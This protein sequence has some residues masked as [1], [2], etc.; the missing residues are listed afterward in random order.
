MRLFIAIDFSKEEKNNLAKAIVNIKEH[1]IS[2]NFTPEENLHLT[3]IFLGETDRLADIKQAMNNVVASSFTL[4]LKD[5]GRFPR[6]DGD[7]YWIGVGE[8]KILLNIYEQL[9][10]SLVTNGFALE[11]RKFKPHLTI[12]RKVIIKKELASMDFGITIGTMNIDVTKISLMKSERIK[13]KLV[14]TPLYSREL[15]VKKQMD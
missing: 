10:S 5:L 3:V 9:Y 2:G 1:A 13:G 12:G 15:V 4:S 6:Q 14:Y 7:I 8:S 11:K